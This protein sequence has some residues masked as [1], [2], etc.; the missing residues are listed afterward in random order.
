M[1]LPIFHD[2]IA[3]RKL[4]NI[5]PTHSKTGLKVFG[6]AAAPQTGTVLPRDQW[7]EVDL[8]GFV[9]KIADQGQVGECNAADT[10]QLLQVCRAMEG[11]PFVELSAGNLY[12]RINGG[13][14]QDNGSLLEDALAEAMKTGIA[15][16]AFA[17]FQDFYPDH[18]KTGWEAD[19]AKHRVLEA[20][21]CPTF[22][23]LTSALQQGFALSVGVTWCD[24]YN[25]DADGWLPPYQGTN[26]GGHAI[27]GVGLAQRNG[28]W[29]IRCANSWTAQWGDKGFF[30]IPEPLFAGPVGGWWACR[31]VVR[32]SDAENL[33]APQFGA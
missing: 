4:G 7:R 15:S 12:G 26:V 27:C 33:P 25:P 1:S 28:V 17:G 20:Y 16:V 31:G 5:A 10:C 32:E 9:T 24:N 13:Y 30:V 19:A 2:G 8:S 3:P 14:G 11:L 18:W 6:S 23:H 29:G 22:D 21:V